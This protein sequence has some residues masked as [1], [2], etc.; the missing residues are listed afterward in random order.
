MIRVKFRDP[1]LT[2]VLK[3]NEI[4]KL[5]GLSE[6]DHDF[7]INDYSMTELYEYL[8][9]LVNQETNQIYMLVLSIL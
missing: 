4:L 3:A 1:S 9:Q 6:I 2:N 8:A 7:A 5:I